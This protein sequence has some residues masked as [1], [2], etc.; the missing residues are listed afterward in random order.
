MKSFNISEEQLLKML[1]EAYES[2]WCGTREMKTEA[3][4][5]IMDKTNITNIT[6]ITPTSVKIP[7]VSANAGATLNYNHH[8][9]MSFSSS[10]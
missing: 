4:K 5:S 9:Y 7:F 1:E 10:H 8:G 2:G 3:A 6:N